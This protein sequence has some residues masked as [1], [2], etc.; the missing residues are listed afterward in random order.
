MA[1][2]KQVGTNNLQCENG[3][4]AISDMIVAINQKVANTDYATPYEGGVIKL[5][6]D[7]TDPANVTLY[8]T[9]DGTDA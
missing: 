2:E 8:I 5:R 3:Q 6:I 9:T 7:D 4:I 1:E